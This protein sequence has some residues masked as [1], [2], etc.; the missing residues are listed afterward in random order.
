MAHKS[1][2]GAS[3]R[4]RSRRAASTQTAGLEVWRLSSD[5]LAPLS[6]EFSGSVFTGQDHRK[7]KRQSGSQQ[8]PD[9]GLSGRSRSSQRAGESSLSSRG[10][11]IVEWRWSGDGSDGPSGQDSC[12]NWSLSRS[13]SLQEMMCPP[14]PGQVPLEPTVTSNGLTAHGA[15]EA[16]PANKSSTEK[17]TEYRER[18]GICGFLRSVW[19]ALK[20]H[21]GCCRHSSAVDVVEP[22]VPPPDLDPEPDPDHSAVKPNNGSFASLFKVGKMIG[23][24]GFGRV[25]EGKRK[26]DGKKVAIKQ[27]SKTDN[28]RYL[29]IVSC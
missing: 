20:H 18:K 10:T 12:G 6:S 16:S 21:F 24:G 26:F 3:G 9:G 8:S 15:V 27:I 22:F 19:K 2:R 4:S 23:S 17:P 7:R 29:D 14:L 1:E 11:Y 25:Y 5:D 28:N 13:D